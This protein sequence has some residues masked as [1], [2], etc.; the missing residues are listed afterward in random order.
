[1]RSADAAASAGREHDCS[2]KPPQFSL[3]VRRASVRICKR[4]HLSGDAGVSAPQSLAITLFA[5]LPLFVLSALDSGTGA[6]AIK[7]PFLYDIEA[8]VRFLLALPLLVVAEVIVDA[9]ISPLIN[10]FVE[11]RIIRTEDMP[12]FIEAVTSAM[13]S[14]DSVAVEATLLLVVYTLGLWLWWGAIASDAATWYAWPEGLDSDSAGRAIGARLSAFRCFSSF[15][16]DYCAL[17]WFR[18]LW[19][20][21]GWTCI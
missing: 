8:H 5:W 16:A 21:S 15:C 1:L 10:R 4:A 7:I 19:R 2:A 6:G 9:R 20:I 18:L 11:R 13:R 14:R 3:S 12:K 17:L